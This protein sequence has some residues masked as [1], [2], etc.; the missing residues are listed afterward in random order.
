VRLTTGVGERHSDVARPTIAIVAVPA[1][2][3]GREPSLVLAITAGEPSPTE[4]DSTLIS[5]RQQ[6]NTPHGGGRPAG[7]A[8]P[9]R[10]PRYSLTNRTAMEPSPT[11][12]AALFT[13]LLRTSPAAN[14]PGVLVSSR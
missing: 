4:D 8:K 6:V 2:G 7:V 10:R 14:T 11:A 1:R 3:T 5:V 9:A 12:A 13:E